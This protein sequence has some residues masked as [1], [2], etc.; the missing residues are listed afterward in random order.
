MSAEQPYYCEPEDGLEPIDDVALAITNE[1]FC[2]G[3]VLVNGVKG[4]LKMVADGVA[5]N[6]D[7]VVVRIPIETIDHLVN[8]VAA[9]KAAKE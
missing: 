8:F 7:G 5:A 2:F 4:E 6:F 1:L 3:V 9:L